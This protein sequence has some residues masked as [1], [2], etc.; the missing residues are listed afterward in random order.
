[1]TAPGAL[2]GIRY[3]KVFRRKANGYWAVKGVNTE[4]GGL[5]GDLVYAVK[6]LG[7]ET[8]EHRTMFN[9]LSWSV[10]FLDGG[11]HHYAADYG[12]S[13]PPTLDLSGN[14]ALRLVCHRLGIV[15]PRRFR[16]ESEIPSVA[17]L[18][19]ELRAEVI[20]SATT[21]RDSR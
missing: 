9:S 19:A 1:M 15:Q 8:S 7:I 14:K 18:E 2:E 13:G 4:E 6:N 20:L 3:S 16:G 5:S 21:R 17:A 10:D 11:L 12:F